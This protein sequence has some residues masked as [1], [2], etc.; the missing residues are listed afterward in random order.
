MA[1]SSP[2]A[3]AAVKHNGKKSSVLPALASSENSETESLASLNT[4]SSES[5]GRE[6][7]GGKVPA[8]KVNI[9]KLSL[10]QLAA[11]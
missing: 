4:L 5:K 8:E 9:M 6:N 1:K 7:D 2:A 10:L 3:A 11:V